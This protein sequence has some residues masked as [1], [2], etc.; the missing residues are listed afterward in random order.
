MHV[1]INAAFL[2]QP[3]VGSGQY[4]RLLVRA[5][6]GLGGDAVYT[7]LVPR[8]RSPCPPESLETPQTPPAQTGRR[9]DA[10]K[11]RHGASLL[12]ASP[13]PRVPVSLLA[14]RGLGGEVTGPPH[15]RLVHVPVPP[16]PRQLPK[17][18]FELVLVPLWARRLAADVLHYPYLCGPLVAAPPTVVTVHD[19]IPL[20]LPAYAPPGPAALYARVAA[21]A[22]TRAAVL[23]ADSAH[24]AHDLARRLGDAGAR[25]RV[26]P[27]APDPRCRPVADAAALAAV[28]ARYGLPERFLL[29]L[30]GLDQRKNLSIVLAAL[31]RLRAND[32][33]PMVV[34][35]RFAPRPPL[36]PDYAAEARARGVADLVRFVGAVTEEDKPALL[37]AARALVFPSRYEG[38]GLPPLEAMACGTPV[39]CSTASSLPEVVGEGALLAAPD[40]LPAWVEALQRIW[41][42]EELV[43]DLRRR[44]R[45]RAAQFGWP[46]TARAVRAA[47]EEAAC[48]S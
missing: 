29:Y 33:P 42:D 19:L 41:A 23:L 36:F 40:D 10:E 17:A 7:L 12:A 15:L 9:G 16:L 13:C 6:L 44:G 45:L 37:S 18:W 14:A 38:F 21:R 22:A 11:R 34:V 30:G 25:A 1:A 8:Y 3:H 4:V 35:G 32:P 46:A 48:V 31:A 39:V 2:D 20:A 5:L 27:L 28:R 47:Y 43:A 26:V 24:T